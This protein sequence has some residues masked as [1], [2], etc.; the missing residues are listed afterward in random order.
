MMSEQHIIEGSLRH[1]R[2]A[3]QMLW[4]NYSGHHPGVCMCYDADRLETEDRQGEP[5]NYDI[6]LLSY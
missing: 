5:G 6:T 1:S 2:K 3:Q 4:K